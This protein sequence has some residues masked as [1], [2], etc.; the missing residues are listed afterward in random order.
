MRKTSILALLIGTGT[1]L[2]SMP[3]S[4]QDTDS[5]AGADETADAAAQDVAGEGEIVVTAQKRTERLQ[6][7]PLAVTAVSGDFLATRQINDTSTLTQA[8]PSLTF[9]QGANP[10]NTSFRIRGVGT[11]LFSQGVESS[12]SVVVDGVVTARQAQG[13]AELA[14]LERIEVLRG[15]QG[16][17]FGKNASAGV[18]NVV[19]ARPSADLSGNASVTIAEGDEYRA[20]GTISGPLSSTLRAR[21]TGYYSNVGGHTQNVTT[22]RD[23]NGYEG[24]GVRGKLEWDATSN[25]NLLLTGDYRKQ[26][27]LCCASTL[28]R[29]DNPILAQL[30]RPVVAGRANRQVSEDLETYANSWQWTASLEANWDLGAATVT[31]ITAYQKYWLDTNQ[32]VDR[33]DSDPIRFVGA[34]ATFA[35]WPLNAGQLDVRQFSQEARIASSGNPDFSYVAGI[36]YSNTRTERPFERRRQLCTAG[37]IGQ[38]CAAANIRNQ[39][40]SSNA[41]LTIDNIAAFGQAEYR[42]VGGLK[43]IGGLRIQHEKGRNE[44]TQYGVLVPGDILL[45][46]SPAPHSGSVKA[47]DTALTGKAG[48]QYEFSRYAQVYATY[49][50]G[51]KGQGYNMEAGT[52]FATQGVLEPEHVNAYEIGFKGTTVD[53]TFSLAAA[54]YRSDYTNLQIQANRSDP[55]TGVVSFVSTNAGTSRSQ[56]VELEAT[57]RPSDKFSLGASL[58]YS[59]STAS[60]DGLNCPLQLQAAAPVFDGNFPVNSCYR[61]SQVVNGVTTVS[62]PRQDLRGATLPSS[63][64][65]RVGLSPRYE[66]EIAGTG[67][68]GFVQLGVNFTSKQQ[69][70]IEQDPLLVQP[71]YTLVDATIG[72]HS[73]DDRYAVSLFVKNLFDVNYF[74]NISHNT[75]LQSTAS[76]YDLAALY[77]KDADRYFGG[78]LS[79]RF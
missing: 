8:I 33:I 51:Y 20:K 40:S 18:I 6:D 38:P 16:T 1:A 21:L 12:V 31:S 26:N 27:S 17:L 71:A 54:I 30:T 45:P 50:R 14:D 49:T 22:G 59:E 47:R 46:G 7:V 58:S 42:V 60:V 36:F 68:S 74:T 79:V 41:L 61:A 67:L 5:A 72:L 64:R 70:A 56:G 77:N 69:L 73:N 66:S 11:Q 75:F 76:P 32:P 29:I 44:G 23:V 4:A 24:W 62:A 37:V 2:V 57:I 15:P 13:F 28:I 35:A 9:Q 52:N 78:T 25:L 3:V 39:S 63:P 48:A 65:F 55:T 53:R 43:L 10:T 19:T 34:G